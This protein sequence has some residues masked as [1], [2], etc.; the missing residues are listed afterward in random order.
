M[1]LDKEKGTADKAE[2]WY[3]VRPTLAPAV[4]LFWIGFRSVSLMLE[5]DKGTKVELWYRVF[6]RCC[7]GQV[8]SRRRGARLARAHSSDRG[9]SLVDS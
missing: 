1:L 7:I 9:S 6:V 3:G 8:A 4:L 5:K 2:L